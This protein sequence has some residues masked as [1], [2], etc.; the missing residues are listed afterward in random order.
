MNTDKTLVNESA[1]SNVYFSNPGMYYRGDWTTGQM[2]YPQNCVTVRVGNNKGLFFCS[3]YIS[4]S[5]SEP[6]NSDP[7]GSSWIKLADLQTHPLTE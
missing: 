6:L 2:Y 7:E 4:G 1:A 3:A 5:L